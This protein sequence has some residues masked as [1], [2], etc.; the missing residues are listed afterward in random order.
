MKFQPTPEDFFGFIFTV[1]GLLALC[2]LAMMYGGVDDRTRVNNVPMRTSQE[3][4]F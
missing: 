4:S 2:G 1:I 3:Q